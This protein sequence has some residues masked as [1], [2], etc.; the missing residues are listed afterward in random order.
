[1]GS[2]GG[3]E[4]HHR[5]PGLPTHRGQPDNSRYAIPIATVGSN[6]RTYV[7]GTSSGIPS[8]SPN[9]FSFTYDVVAITADGDGFPAKV[10]VSGN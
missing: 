2:P 1:M 9:G 5:L 10:N 3:R 8:E 4:R 6:A 7:H